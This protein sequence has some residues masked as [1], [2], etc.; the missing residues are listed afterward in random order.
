MTD[1]TA[2]SVRSPDRRR[3]V[4]GVRPE[5]IRGRSAGVTV[6]AVAGLVW[7]ASTEPALSTAVWAPMLAVGATISMV[8]IVGAARLRRTAIG[9]PVPVPDSPDR[10]AWRLRVAFVIAAECVAIIAAVNILGA[11][12][13]SHWMPAT[14]CAVVGLHFAPLGRLFQVPLYYGTAVALCSVA[15]TT[16]I[17]GEVGTSASTWTSIPGFGAGLTLWATSAT[18][19]VGSTALVHQASARPDD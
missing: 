15:A 6:G 5:E 9:L 7:A 19:L 17:V 16:A 18:L 10:P 8:L 2:L 14:V 11:T 4:R 13:H 12:G 1:S 3:R